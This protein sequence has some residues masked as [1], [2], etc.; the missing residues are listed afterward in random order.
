MSDEPRPWMTS[1]RI[2]GQVDATEADLA[3]RDYRERERAREEVL[4]AIEAGERSHILTIGSPARW[5]CLRV[6]LGKL[7]DSGR[8]YRWLPDVFLIWNGRRL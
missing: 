8:W 4:A 3:L 5:L 1:E 6:T 7:T 2:Y